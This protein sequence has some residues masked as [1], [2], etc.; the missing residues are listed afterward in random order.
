MPEDRQAEYLEEL[1]KL[2]DA[3]HYRAT[4]ADYDKMAVAYGRGLATPAELSRWLKAYEFNAARPLGW[5]GW[6][7]ATVRMK[8]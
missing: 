7:A 1:D 3:Y 6:V 2:A 4:L 5:K 8:V